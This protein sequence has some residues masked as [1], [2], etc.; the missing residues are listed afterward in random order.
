M[1]TVKGYHINVLRLFN[2][3]WE[4]MKKGNNEY[5]FFLEKGEDY[6]KVAIETG[7][8]VLEGKKTDLEKKL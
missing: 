7:K 1:K 4:K 6:K 5:Y 3:G 2:Q 8:V